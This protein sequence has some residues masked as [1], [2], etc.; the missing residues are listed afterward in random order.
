MHVDGKWR[1]GVQA[2]F[3]ATGEYDEENIIEISEGAV[4]TS[5]TY[6]RYFEKDGK[7]YHHIIDPST[8]YPSEQ[9]YSSVTVVTQSGLLGDCLS[10][11]CFVAG[12]DGAVKLAEAFGAKTGATVNVEF[13]G[14]DINSIIQASLEAGDAIDMFESSLAKISKNYINYCL[15]LC[16][17]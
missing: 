5:G 2:P 15:F 10:T 1:I 3:E 11:A 12:R 8:G 6:Q 16:H 9:E 4:I 13:K 7:L 14:R 17:T